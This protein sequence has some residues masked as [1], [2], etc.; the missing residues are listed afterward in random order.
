MSL[1][2]GR[3]HFR[4]GGLDP[5]LQLVVV[6]SGRSLK[7]VVNQLVLDE[8][9]LSLNLE[10]VGSLNLLLEAKWSCLP[11]QLQDSRQGLW[12]SCDSRHPDC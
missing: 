10:V 2:L 4:L 12:A 11:A 9:D 3:C 1:G 7:V 8:L 5:D 6:V